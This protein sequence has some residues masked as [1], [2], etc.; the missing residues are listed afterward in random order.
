MSVSE[1]GYVP[2][3]YN[4]LSIHLMHAVQFLGDLQ[5]QALSQITPDAYRGPTVERVDAME[6][7]AIKWWKDAIVKQITKTST[8][9]VAPQHILVVSHGGFIG[10]LI[11]GLL[12]GRHISQ[13]TVTSIGRLLNTAVTEIEVEPTA[14]KGKLI[15]FGDV[16]HL[17]K[18]VIFLNSDEA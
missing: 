2:G 12:G 6:S 13:G 15:R 8:G 9:T 10:T 5:G 11:R 16:T 17:S 3:A 4:H 18:S 1:S 7:R 14:G